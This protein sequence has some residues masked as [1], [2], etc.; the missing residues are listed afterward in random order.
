[1]RISTRISSTLMLSGFVFLFLSGLLQ[2]QQPKSFQLRGEVGFDDNTSPN[3]LVVEIVDTGAHMPGERTSVSFNGVF[4]LN[5]ITTPNI[6]LRVLNQ[7]GDVLRRDHLYLSQHT[8]V[9]SLRLNGQAKERPVQG[10]VSAHRLRHKPSSRAMKE[11]VKADQ[12]FKKGDVAGSLKH[13]EAA[14]AADPE[15]VEAL[16]NLGSRYIQT[17]ENLKALE[18]LRQAQTLDPDSGPTLINLGIVLLQ[19]KRPAEAE[20]AARHALRLPHENNSVEYI[21]GMSLVEQQKQLPQ[22]LRYMQMAS[23]NFPKA[24]IYAANIL[25][26]TGRVK[27]AK[28]ELQNYLSVSS[29]NK[30]V[31]QRWMKSLR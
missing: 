15:F 31:I 13:L 27:E 6:E 20:E 21:L 2:A 10:T 9:L 12:K 1:M 7:S 17:G 24:H 16:T 30:E 25:A 26:R 22:A 3:G 19:L 28:A 5:N 11:F 18:V 8:T 14:V 29:E 23:A 4:E